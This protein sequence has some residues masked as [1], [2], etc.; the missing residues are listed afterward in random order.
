MNRRAGTLIETLGQ[1]PDQS[2]S[3]PPV[4]VGRRPRPPIGGSIPTG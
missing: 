3:P 2:A 1:R 4:G